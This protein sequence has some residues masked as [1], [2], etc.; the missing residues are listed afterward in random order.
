MSE[1]A[2]NH[3]ADYPQFGGVFGY[4]AGL[5]MVVGRGRDARLVA[6]LA[7]VGPADRVLDI[8]CGPGTAARHAAGRGAS[9]I[10]VDPSKPMLQLAR[11]ITRIRQP[12]A[13]VSWRLGSAESMDVEEASITA[14]WSL[15][16]VHH[17]QDLDAGLDQVERALAPGGRFLA[18][19][20]RSEPDATGNAGH[21]WTAGQAQLFASMLT[22]RGFVDVEVSNHTIG[23]LVGKR[24][25]VVVGGSRPPTEHVGG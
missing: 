20:K 22:G 14:C 23:H 17:W 4:L 10:G 12:S 2:P 15:A 9:V 3:H 24:R 21:G 13:P 7:A 18:V 1:L 6:D 25:I 8:G 5:T 19:E 11:A 16:S